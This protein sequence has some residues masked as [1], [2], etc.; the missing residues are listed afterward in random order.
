MQVIDYFTGFVNRN[1]L[2]LYKKVAGDF[3]ILQE[4]PCHTKARKCL[5]IK[6][7]IICVC[8]D[9]PQMAQLAGVMFIAAQ[10]ARARRMR[11][12]H[13]FLTNFNK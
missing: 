6:E 12:A 4:R 5:P 10:S 8:S 11:I 7:K 1:L 13:S 3:F 9:A 2:L